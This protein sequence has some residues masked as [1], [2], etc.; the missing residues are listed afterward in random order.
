MLRRWL[1]WVCLALLSSP[2]AADLP[3]DLQ[4][5]A[6]LILLD[7]RIYTAANRTMADA[8]VVR[9]DRLLYVG[10]EARA[11]SFRRPHTRVLRLHGRLVVPGLIDAHIHPIDIL[12]FDVCDLDNAPKSLSQ[13][14]PFVRACLKRYRLKPG[15]WLYV[16]QWNPG[17]ANQPDAALPTLRAALDPC[18][19]G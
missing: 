18:R 9:G 2:R 17:D 4:S 7:A 6:D 13:L 15:E 14:V 1:P 10:D 5:P 8:L 3:P 19:P 12:D 11:L 16:H